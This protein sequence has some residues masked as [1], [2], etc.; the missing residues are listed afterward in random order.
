MDQMKQLERR[1]I[2]PK[3]V[4]PDG[5]LT[6]PRSYGVYQLSTSVGPTRTFRFGNH[7]VRMMELEREFGVCQLRCLFRSREEACSMAA[8]LNKS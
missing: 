4:K 6:M 3:D 1:A 8:L 2:S 7:P 5:V